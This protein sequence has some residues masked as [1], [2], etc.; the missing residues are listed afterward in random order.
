MK[1]KIILSNCHYV[2]EINY[3]LNAF[4]WKKNN[5]SHV[6]LYLFSGC[7]P[8]FST[9][10]SLPRLWTWLPSLSTGRTKQNNNKP[11]IFSI[12][13][14]PTFSVIQ[15]PLFF[16]LARCQFLSTVKNDHI[17][18]QV[19]CNIFVKILRN[20]YSCKHCNLYFSREGSYYCLIVLQNVTN[21]SEFC[22]RTAEN[23]RT[24]VVIYNKKSFQYLTEFFMLTWQEAVWVQRQ[25]KKLLPNWLDWQSYLAA[26]SKSHREI[27]ISCF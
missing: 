20:W 8:S 25:G 17:L 15:L 10:M 13:Q 11:N 27:S 19:L 1:N 14:F 26:S 16:W 5:H 18:P 7:S 6:C 3:L 21:Y 22:F 2:D 23:V 9:E 24:R 4:R 12:F